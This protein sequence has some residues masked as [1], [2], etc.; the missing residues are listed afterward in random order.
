MAE[1]EIM[2][3]SVYF[4]PFHQTLEKELIGLQRDWLGPLELAGSL[5]HVYNE[6]QVLLPDE[7]PDHLATLD[8]EASLTLALVRAYGMDGWLR[9]VLPAADGGVHPTLDSR[10]LCLIRET[11]SYHSA[12]ADTAF[13]MQ[14]LGSHPIV[15]VGTQ[16]QRQ[17]WL[18]QVA[19]GKCITG[20]AITEHRAGSDVAALE[21]RAVKVEGGYRITGVKTF[22]SNAGVAD[23]YTLFAR[24]GGPG[25]DG[26]SCFVLPAT[27]PGLTIKSF[28][29]IAPH[30]IGELRLK[31]VFVPDDHL[32]GAPGDGFSIAMG[33]LERFRPTV[34]AAALGIAQRALDEA[35]EYT[36][37]RVQFGKKL[38]DQ[39]AV[40]MR[41]AEM[42]VAIEASRLLVFQAAWA[43]DHGQ[44][45]AGVLASMAKLHA[46]EAA[47]QVVDSAVQ[48][49]GGL[50]VVS[51]VVVERL[52]REVRALRIYEGT[53]EIQKF[54][55]G[56]HMIKA[57]KKR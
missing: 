33:T 46:T 48:L 16:E 19:S 50:G 3:H 38:C 11:I 49:F 42:R 17:R 14:G 7:D 44:E 36:S 28:T 52:Y 30:P 29:L 45:D 8:E 35:L 23:L 6:G 1:G 37:M 25:K 55:I 27:S 21:A 12:L 10:S 32:L 24:T 26:I 41:L 56:A 54:I 20:F 22:I 5:Q 53:S 31:E 2:R 34:G 15:L 39:Q 57:S 43:K 47:Q 51:G 13:A 40:R 9:H 18:P 4:D